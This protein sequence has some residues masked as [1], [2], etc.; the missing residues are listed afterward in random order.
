MA[1]YRFYY[2]RTSRAMS[3]LLWE[4]RRKSVFYTIH[5]SVFCIVL[6]LVI[7]KKL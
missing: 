6:P 7:G 2:S 4:N 3:M 5:F 1:A